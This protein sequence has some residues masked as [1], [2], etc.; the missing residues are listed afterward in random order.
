MGLVWPVALLA[1]MLIMIGVLL[2]VFVVLYVRNYR[3]GSLPTPA[4]RRQ[5]PTQP[6]APPQEQPVAVVSGA[7]QPPAVA[8]NTA[9]LEQVGDGAAM[10]FPLDRP[11]TVIGRDPSCDIRIDERFVTVSRRHA[12]I[13]REEDSYVL[14]DLN[15]SGGVYVNGARIG[16]NRIRDGAIIRLGE[17]VQYTFHLNRAREAP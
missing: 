16:R 3:H 14:S 1:I 2:L 7:R 13:T 5:P 8:P 15:S 11:V 4:Q 10:L 9:Y 17:G 12:E 6:P